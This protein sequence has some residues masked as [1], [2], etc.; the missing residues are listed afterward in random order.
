MG[1]I[2]LFEHII[3]MKTGQDFNTNLITGYLNSLII[4][5]D[6]CV[7]VTIESSLGYL[8][9]HNAQHK[10]INYYAPRALLQGAISH[11]AVN[12]QF[13]KFKLNESLNIRVM[14]PADSKVTIILRID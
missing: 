2:N 4:D 8:I 7:S 3:E 5:S 10:G 6:E 11:L 9:F 1:T 13:D 14:G 12:D